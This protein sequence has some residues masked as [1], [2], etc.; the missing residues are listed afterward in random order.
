MSISP[1]LRHARV[2]VSLLGT[3]DE[4]RQVR[5]GLAAA[6]GFLRRKL[7]ER[8]SLRYMPDLSFERDQSLEQGSRL[9]GLIEKVSS[10]DSLD[11]V[12]PS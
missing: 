6:S 2:F 3:E 9:L 12:D 10:G 4:W 7:G 11:E 5:D 8:L 1:D